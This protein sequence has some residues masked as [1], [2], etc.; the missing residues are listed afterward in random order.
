[1][2]DA[3]GNLGDFIG[4]IAVVVTLLYL[5]V[6]VRQNTTALQTAS[7]QAVVTAY[8][9]SNRL[10]CD[11]AAALAWAKGLTAFPDLPFEE[12]NFFATIMVDEALCFQG[13]FALHDS[14]QL[15]ESTYTA[16]LDWFASI[17][18]TPGGGVWWETVGRPV[19]V[20]AM[21]TAV[22]ERLAAGDLHDIRRM[23]AIRLEEPPAS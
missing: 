10:R 19:F 5:A 16:Y 21:V 14:G 9:E 8:R 6:Q 11:S 12:R 20:G 22:D 4:G 3:L 17:A 23:P 18:A 1:M 2:L 15:A 7:W 13:A